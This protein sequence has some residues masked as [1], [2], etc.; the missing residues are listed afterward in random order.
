MI[1]SRVLIGERQ[2]QVE[3]KQNTR[4]AYEQ[5]VKPTKVC[6][7][8]EIE[9]KVDD[10]DEGFNQCQ[11]SRNDTKQEEN[12]ARLRVHLL[13]LDDNIVNDVKA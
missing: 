12:V 5:D 1:E 11:T 10:V 2:Q 8:L 13:V 9:F 3:E 6:I 7:F 4:K